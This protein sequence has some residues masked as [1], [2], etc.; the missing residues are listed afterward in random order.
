M[1]GSLSGLPLR[2][3]LR[4]GA[5]VTAANWPVVLIQFAL[6]SVYRLGVS[7]PVVGGVFVLAVLAGADVRALLGQ[8]LQAAGGM[9]AAGLAGRPEALLTF[10]VAVGVV[11]I[12]GGVLVFLMHAGTASVLVRGEH[13]GADL[14]RAPLRLAHIRETN[15]FGIGEFLAGVRRFG[16]RFVLLGLWLCVAYVAVAVAA[17]A[18]LRVLVTL[19][20]DHQGPL[21][22]GLGVLV[23]TTG[24]LIAIAGF[25]LVYALL[26]VIMATDDCRLSQALGRL[27]A[28]VT[29]DA[30]RVAGIFGVVLGLVLLASA[31][32]LL[33]TAGLALVAWVPV[34][35]LAVV[36]LQ[37]AAWLLRGL[38]FHYMELGAW[39][40]YQSQY[41]RYAD[42]AS[43][44]VVPAW[45]GRI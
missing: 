6:V 37:L 22:W 13:Q 3:A 33:A 42:P 4:R 32:S 29:H 40:A 44:N 18:A 31:A 30:R 34:V 8:D 36:P 15:A 35:G 43:G 27:H 16:R 24:V 17:V 19:S 10:L 1:R 9:V 5:L 41:R 20:G 21:V 28:F 39:S 23:V 7:V 11:A 2:A 25:N 26:Q 38:I 14:H 45:E 12:G